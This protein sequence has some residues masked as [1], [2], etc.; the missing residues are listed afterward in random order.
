MN[1]A[2]TWWDVLD[3][4]TRQHLREDAGVRSAA[5]MR[6][7]VIFQ[8]AKGIVCHDCRHAAHVLR[9]LRP[10][11]QIQKPAPLCR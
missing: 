6:R 7:T 2:K 10:D 11:L 3:S 4:S 5:G 8:N 1:N 9:A